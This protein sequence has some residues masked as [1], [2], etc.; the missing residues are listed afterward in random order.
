MKILKI[1]CIVSLVAAYLY[2][3][4]SLKDESRQVL[5]SHF[6]GSHIN[7]LGNNPNVYEVRDP[8]NTFLIDYLVIEA[9][10]GW[11][12]PMNIGTLIDR[13]GTIKNVFVFNHRETPAFFNDLT[14]KGFIAR[15]R[16][17]PVTAPFQLGQDVDAV[18]GATISSAAL[19]KAVRKSGHWL[20]RSMLGFDINEPPLQWKFGFNELSLI[21]LFAVVLFFSI[22]KIFK[23][24]RIINALSIVFLGFYLNAS[25]SVA[26]LTSL[27]MGYAPPLN[28][29]LLWWLVV[30]GTLLIIVGFG[31]NLYCGWMCPWF[32]LQEYI[33]II[34]GLRL[35]M[36][37]K[38]A[39]MAGRLV[40][41]LLWMSLMIIFTTRN[42]AAGSY[43]PFGTLF[44][45]KG[46]GIQWYLLA[47]ALLGSL[48]IP[49]FWC[50]FFCP[51]G[52]SLFYLVKARK[53]TLSCITKCM[54][55]K[56]LY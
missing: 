8:E 7:E 21:V 41:F 44:G 4:V 14:N 49:R 48:A 11:G 6:P 53:G 22:K 12:G 46:I 35:K 43:E 26:N 15:F 31:K 9:V 38:A 24:R 36:N 3:H 42:P 30:V 23:P 10:N 40:Y 20:G 32:G 17:L 13:Q 25:I 52:L 5:K 16:E 45:L 55:H 19:T 37:E 50:R 39:R 28:E 34:G 18:S 47:I 56:T 33:S 51:V 1:L 27:L 29:N 54:N 2:G